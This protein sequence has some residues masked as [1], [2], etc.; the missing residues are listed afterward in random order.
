MNDDCS[1]ARMPNI[2]QF[3]VDLQRR[4]KVISSA[5]QRGVHLSPLECR[6]YPSALARHLL[7]R[8]LSLRLDSFLPGVCRV[9]LMKLNWL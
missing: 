4:G 8:R 6:V 9:D 5:F 2:Y 3:T 7:Y 1:D